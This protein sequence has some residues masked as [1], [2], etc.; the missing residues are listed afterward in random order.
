MQ[1]VA[2]GAAEQIN[3]TATSGGTTSLAGS[4]SA[5]AN[6]G[7]QIQVFTGTMGHTI[8][9]PDATTML[10]G[11]KFEINN[12]SL[13][14]LTLQFNGGASFTDAA[15]VN[16]SSL[17]S[18][19][20][21]V[22]KLQTNGTSAGT[23]AASYSII[24]PFTPL[25]P[26]RQEFLSGSGTYITPSTPSPLYIQVRLIGGGGGG[27]GGFMSSGIG[28]NGGTTTFGPITANGGA[29][30]D[31]TGLVS[32][33]G[34]ASLGVGPVGLARTGASGTA[35]DGLV[36]ESGPPGA[37]S[38]FAGGGGGG[39]TGTGSAGGDAPPNT[40][41]GGGGGGGGGALPEGGSGAAGGFVDARIYS[42]ATT[43]SWSVGA[44]GTFGA[45]TNPGGAGSEGMI[46][47][48]EFYQ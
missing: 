25:V 35:G 37:S 9:L 4:T 28:G 22:L 16:Y 44:G 30:G 24:V 40:G 38:P 1:L 33:G 3:I 2:G 39:G 5:D 34:T 17:T 26:T 6:L 31:K 19:T 14:T 18:H 43:Y 27:C 29:G 42:P 41:A 15:G 46:E 32:A 21:I 7:K 23:W 36:D 8:V 45:A 10:V 20:T 13:L 47:V 48:W 11:Q 12:Q